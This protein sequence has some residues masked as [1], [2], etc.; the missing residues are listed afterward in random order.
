M[1]SKKY[2]YA[3]DLALLYASRNWKAVEHT[4]SQDMTTLSAYLQTGRLKLSN[5]KTV[6]A[7]FH[8]NNREAKRELNVYNNG[9]LLPRCSFPAYLGVK[10]DRS[11]T[12]RHHLEALRKKTLHPN[13]AV[14]ATCG[15]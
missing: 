8:L 12:F 15:I 6:T 9:N 13:G 14:E 5:M 10:L 11:L 3:D 7:A 4:L 2:A 1:T